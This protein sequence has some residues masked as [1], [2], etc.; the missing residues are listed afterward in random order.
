[1]TL[2][3]PSNE[4]LIAM[5]ISALISR[6]KP[7]DLY[8]TKKLKEIGGFD[9]NKVRKLV[10]FYLSL[11]NIFEIND[12]MY[13]GINKINQNSIKKELYPVINKTEHFNLESTKLNIV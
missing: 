5:K 10:L 1:M 8:D 3:T 4:E 11:D 6:S 12:F 7:R 13:D 2:L 9:K